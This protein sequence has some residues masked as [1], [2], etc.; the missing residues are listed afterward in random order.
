FLMDA[1]KLNTA[2]ING[3]ASGDGNVLGAW[4][5]SLGYSCSN[6]NP[7]YNGLNGGYV[8]VG[9]DEYGN[10][11]NGTSNTLGESGTSATGDNTASG[12]GSRPGRTGWRGAGTVSW[13]PL[14]GA[15]GGSSNPG[16]TKPWSP[17]S[18]ATSCLNAGGTYNSTANAC[19]SCSNSGTYNAGSNSC[20]TQT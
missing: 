19:V 5:G 3:V 14:N 16:S 1:S 2:T 4:G 10:F 7:P 12:G 9:I 17:S 18:L 20:S 13:L 15:Y 8:A 11:L 6:S